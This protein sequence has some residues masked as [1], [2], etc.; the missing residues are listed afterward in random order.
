MSGVWSQPRHM[1]PEEIAELLKENAA[2]KKRIAEWESGMVVVCSLCCHSLSPNELDAYEDLECRQRK[3]CDKVCF[4]CVG[5]ME[6]DEAAYRV[7]TELAEKF[8]SK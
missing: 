3:W 7:L 6:E 8:K 1:N 5:Q 4:S 2:L